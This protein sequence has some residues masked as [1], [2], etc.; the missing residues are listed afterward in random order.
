MKVIK[1]ACL[2][3]LILLIA[4]VAAAA[5]SLTPIPPNGA[6]FGTP[7][8]TIGW[9]FTISN[10]TDSLVV[11]SSD[12]CVG[13]IISPCTNSLG[14]YSDIIG[15][16]FV[17]VGPAPES[18]PVTQSFDSM[19]LTGLGSFLV[20]AGAIPGQS[21]TGAVVVTYDLYSVDP[22]DPNFDP[23]VDTISVG[24]LLTANAS[25]TATPEPS[26]IFGF[27]SGIAGTLCFLRHRRTPKTKI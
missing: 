7:G 5:A 13:L 27:G 24:N 21:V 20:K 15:P 16:N 22:N 8:S 1:F 10:N 17:I 12:F 18:T 25:V 9:G 6:I 26:T 11:T 19:L 14:S 4:Q 3:S 2:A 23:G